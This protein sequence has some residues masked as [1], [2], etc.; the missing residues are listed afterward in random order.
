[1]QLW[2]TCN[3]TFHLIIIMRSFSYIINFICKLETHR[4][5]AS[6]A[7]RSPIN[8]VLGG[9]CSIAERFDAAIGEGGNC[10]RPTL[11]SH[12]QPVGPSRLY[13]APD[14]FLSLLRSCSSTGPLLVSIVYTV[15]RAWLSPAWQH[16]FGLNDS[17]RRRSFASAPS[18]LRF[19]P[20]YAGVDLHHRHVG[21]VL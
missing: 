18:Q 2:Y 21:R 11:I 16:R 20:P 5:Y 1:M 9:I 6:I 15:E 7:F 8:V 14:D 4:Y 12:P 3:P 19:L 13:E 17:T 10:R